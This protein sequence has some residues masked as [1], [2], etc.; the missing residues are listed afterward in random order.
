[1]RKKA[2]RGLTCFQ[3]LFLG[4]GAERICA[5]CGRSAFSNSYFAVMAFMF[6]YSVV[7]LSAKFYVWFFIIPEN[8]LFVFSRP[9]KPWH[10]PLQLAPL[11]HSPKK[12]Q[13]RLQNGTS[14]EG[15]TTQKQRVGVTCRRGQ[16]ARSAHAGRGACV[17]C[18][19]DG[20]TAEAARPAHKPPGH[21][22]HS[23]R[24]RR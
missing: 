22:P 4:R 21:D 23:A 3:F 5:V 10:S 20:V 16:R 18:S 24:A 19:A 2:W 7:K 11:S 1:M 6:Y 13:P 12:I 17:G 8:F 15:E 14:K 9:T